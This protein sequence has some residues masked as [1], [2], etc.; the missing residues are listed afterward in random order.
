[1]NQPIHIAFDQ[2]LLV[3]IDLPTTFNKIV[4]STITTNKIQIQ[5]GRMW[6]N[7]Q[8][9]VQIKCY[10]SCCPV[11]YQLPVVQM[12]QPTS[13]MTSFFGQNS[14]IFEVAIAESKSF[15]NMHTFFLSVS[16]FLKR[17]FEN[18]SIRRHHD[19]KMT[20]YLKIS[21]KN[22]QKICP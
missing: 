21:A 18:F 19:I 5:A 3:L 2:G 9:A 11:T 14:Q 12:L 15:R 8:P 13:C 6:S 17:I 16:N 22:S 4:G 1:M 7:H 10:T 20:S